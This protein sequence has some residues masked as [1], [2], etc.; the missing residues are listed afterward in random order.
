MAI[1]IND[2]NEVG[3]EEEQRVIVV[4]LCEREDIT[5]AME[6]LH[7]LAKAAGATVV[8]EMVQNKQKIDP[9]FFI[10]KGKVEEL[11]T[12][13]IGLGANL[14]I[15]ND[16]LSGVQLRNLENALDLKVIDRTVLILDIFARRASSK[17]GKLQVELAQLKYAKARMIGM[18]QSL[19]RTGG[20]IGTRGPGEKKLETDRR[21]LQRR[22]LEIEKELAAIR[23]NRGTQRA[24]RIK[25]EVPVVS[26]VGYT[27]S[28]KSTIMNAMLRKVEKEEKTVFEKDMLFA[29]LDTFQRNIT[30]DSKESFVLIDTVGFVSKLPHSLI[31]AFKATL[32]E[33]RYSDLLVHVVDAS[34]EKIEFQMDVTN[35]IISEIVGEDKESIV[36]FNK[37]DKVDYDKSLLPVAERHL[38]ISAKAEQGID[39]IIEKIKELL[40][41]HIVKVTLLI[42]FDQGSIT[43]YLCNHTAVD[44]MDY[45][46]EGVRIETNLDHVDIGKY[47]QYIIEDDGEK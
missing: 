10:G 2:Q 1:I 47:G 41:S 39:E 38:Y 36:V 27:N 28:G 34:N 11:R 18:N 26:L 6:E 7:E 9:A 44:Q 24:K 5:D 42:P 12:A 21:Y 8:G 46:E 35:K 22:M 23:K 25:S 29:T 19:S 15:F 14:I 37:M 31:N 4:G 32:E 45:V 20:G 13:A 30:L 43:S 40:F 33:V 17:E 3:I 16:E